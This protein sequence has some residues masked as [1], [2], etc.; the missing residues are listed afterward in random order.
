MV[1]GEGGET[2][3]FNKLYNNQIRVT[4]D[5][6]KMMM[7]VKVMNV[8]KVKVAKVMK[9]MIVR[10]VIW[11]MV[12]IVVGIMGVIDNLQAICQYYRV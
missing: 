7:K 8:M 9:A 6:M 1:E 3:I 11:G 4:L 10:M 12:M 5:K 2:Q